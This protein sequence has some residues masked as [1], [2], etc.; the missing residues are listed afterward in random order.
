M[1]R[2]DTRWA[3]ALAGL[4]LMTPGSGA[5]GQRTLSAQT[6]T[7]AAAPAAPIDPCAAPANKIIAENCKPG[8]PSTEWDINGWG[9]PSIQGFA[10]DISYNL[11]Q[12]AEFKIQTPSNRYRVDIYRMGYYGGLGARLVGTVRPSAPLPQVQPACLEDWSVRLYD[13]GNWAVSASWAIPADATSG[14]H[15]ARLVRE[16]A[17]PVGWRVDNAPGSGGKPEAMPHAYGA[18]GMGK[19][20]NALKEPRASH[21]IFIV[22]D[23]TSKADVV[24]Q[25]SDPTW[26]AYNTYGLGSS[27]NGLTAT[28]ASGGRVARA[29]KVSFNR[30]FLNRTSGSVNQFFNAEYALA[31][32]LERNGYDTT[33]FAGVDTDRRGELLTNHKLYISIGHDE[34]WSGGAR[35]NV[36][37]A[38]DTGVNLAF[39]SG[40]EVFW[41]TRY[42]NSIDGSKT[43]YR[44][45]VVYK[46]THS[47]DTPTNELQPGKSIDPTDIW[48][49]TWRESSAFNPEGAYPENA[50]TGNRFA[51]SMPTCSL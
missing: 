26:Q 4:A 17:P 18:L 3:L 47:N 19:N 10:T 22:R 36:E 23:D 30:P 5:M 46:E 7:Q 27:Y 29:N 28:G 34:Y 20:E 6:R 44:T 31:R 38:R 43:P 35:K 12:T 32:W 13:C 14:V 45:L 50:L 33:Y 49:G 40:N 37:A 51:S 24:M 8:N 1:K 16:D 11:G 48:T 42:E 9:D 2:F 21:I 41:K 39:M 25:T 15:V